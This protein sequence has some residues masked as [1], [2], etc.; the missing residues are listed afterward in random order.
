MDRLPLVLYL[1]VPGFWRSIFHNS[2][3]F[4]RTMNG[5][6]PV[7]RSG[8]T[9]RKPS[10]YIRAMFSLDC[11]PT[12]VSMTCEYLQL[13]TYRPI[14][15]AR[16]ASNPFAIGTIGLATGEGTC[17]GHSKKYSRIESRSFR[18]AWHG[19]TSRGQESGTAFP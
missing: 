17:N 7:S 12:S 10:L 18:S 2:I 1:R 16:Q 5:G 8:P 13:A 11:R 3:Q 19:R 4:Q 9:W 6:A 14:L 15:R